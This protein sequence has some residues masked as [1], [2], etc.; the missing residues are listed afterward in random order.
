MEAIARSPAF[1]VAGVFH[2]EP[3]AR[4]AARD[5][6]DAGF[7]PNA[8]NLGRSVAAPDAAGARRDETSFL[9]HLVWIIV[10][11]SVPGTVVGAALGWGI[12][13]AAGID[14]TTGIVLMAVSFGILGHLVAGIWAG[15]LRLADRSQRE[16]TPSPPA[17]GVT[18]TVRCANRPELQRAH[19]LLRARGAVS[20]RQYAT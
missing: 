1:N 16:F 17:G 15:Y 14:D 6:Q 9:G 8:I 11:W 12:A 2:D 4:Q 19:A 13:L 20:I 3:A 18:V 10:W 7:V 5:L